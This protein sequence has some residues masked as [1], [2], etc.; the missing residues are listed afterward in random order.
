MQI[1]KEPRMDIKDVFGGMF[2]FVGLLFFLI[3]IHVITINSAGDTRE[4]MTTVFTVSLNLFYAFLIFA[5]AYII[6]HFLRWLVWSISTPLWLK[7]KI[8]TQRR[9]QKK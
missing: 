6:I 2:V 1:K 4:V 8:R 5:G 7:D 9:L 3:L